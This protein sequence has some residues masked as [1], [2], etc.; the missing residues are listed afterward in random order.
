MTVR[1]APRPLAPFPLRSWLGSV[2]PGGLG[3]RVG[4]VKARRSFAGCQQLL[5]GGVITSSP[6]A[7]FQKKKALLAGSLVEGRG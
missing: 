2:G 3:S 6:G 5:P 7:L 1:G 4:P